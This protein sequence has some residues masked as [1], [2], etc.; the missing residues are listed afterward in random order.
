M[1]EKKIQPKLAQAWK[2][3]V[4]ES[5]WADLASDTTWVRLSCSHQ[6]V[7][8][9]SAPPAMVQAHSAGSSL[10]LAAS[11]TR[12]TPQHGL[13]GGFFHKPSTFS[14][15]L[16]GSCAHPFDQKMG[17]VYWFKPTWSA[18]PLVC[19]KVQGWQWG[20]N[21]PSQAD[22][23]CCYQERRDDTLGAKATGV[24]HTHFTMRHSK[25]LVAKQLHRDWLT[26]LL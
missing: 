5:L 15:D 2:T 22:V 4:L 7:D 19:P 14:L 18:P 1:A 26:L 23:E 13:W 3:D 8:P 21:S 11:D 24:P 25:P 9:D 10:P 16:T 17:F 12:H 6:V 20:R